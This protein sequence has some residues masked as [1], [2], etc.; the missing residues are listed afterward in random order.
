MKSSPLLL[1]GLSLV[2]L[3]MALGVAVMSVD[4][5]A[6]WMKVAVVSP[7][8]PMEIALNPE[9]KRKT[10]VA[11]SIKDGE[12]KFGSDAMGVCVKSP[13]NCYVYMFDL[14]GKKVDH[15]MVKAYQARF[16]QYKIEADP[17]RGTVVFRHD[18]DTTYSVEELLGMMFAH[19]KTQ[20][21]SFTEQAVKDAVI[22]TPVYF[23]QAER[24]ALVA[25]AQLGGLNVLQLMNVPMAV[26]L[27]YGMFRRKEINGTV[28]HLMLYDMGAQ[29]TTATIVGFQVVK[30]KEK[31]FSE[32]HPQAQILGV[33]YD[34][35]LGGAEIRFRVRDYL[36]DQFNALGKTKTDVKS[37][38]RAMG[39]LLKEAERVKLILSANADC[40]AQIEN[41]MED[42]DFKV[43]MSRDK[44]M[45]LST[46]LMDRVTGPVERALSTA[47]MSIENIDQVI[48]VG[49]GTRV[50]RV[51][52]LLSEYVGQELGKSLNTDESAAMGAV[53][54]SADIS[55]GFK[56]KKFLMKDAVLLPIDVDFSREIEA[57]E[58]AG[59][60][61]V[62]R[63][64]RTLFSRM[65]PY[66]Q[67]K[68][69][70]FNKHV[71]DFTFNV[72]YADLDYLGETEVAHIGSHNLTSVLVKGVKG[73]LDGNVE[74]NI[75]TKGVKAHFQ[76]DDSGILTCTHVES[77]F[78]KTISPE[79]QEKKEKDWKEATESIDWSK[80][81]DNIKNFFGTD[82]KKEEGTEGDEEKEEK[83]EDKDDVKKEKDSKDTKKEEKKDKKDEKS[84]EPKKPK[85]ESVKVELE[86]D[87]TRNDLELLD[88]ESFNSSKAKLDE[89]NQ[90]D[91][92]RLAIETALNELQSFSFD[93][94][95]KMEDDEFQSASSAEERESVV[96]ECGKVSEWLDD[97]AGMFTPVEEFTTKLK[98][99]KDLS[100]PIMARVREHK[101]RPEALEQLRQTINSSNVFL[102]KSKEYLIKPKPKE[103]KVEKVIEPVVETAGEEKEGANEKAKETAE[104]KPKVTK[105][106][107]VDEEGLFKE[108]ELDSLKKKIT[109]VEKWRD[110]KL[111]EQEKTPLAE[112]PK[113]TVSM[114]KSKIQDLDSEV[115]FLIQKARM[116]KAE[117]EREKRKLEAEEKK[118]EEE[119]LKKEKKAKKKK[120]K[121]ANATDTDEKVSEEVPPT[122]STGEGDT[123]TTEKKPEPEIVEEVNEEGNIKDN[124]E[125]PSEVP[126]EKTE[127]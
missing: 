80:L 43:P 105:A 98:V 100:A 64:R 27:N 90:A 12:R 4:I 39:K 16:P 29:A 73:A 97:E 93:L 50:P 108:K 88:G 126:E 113:L 71:K 13:K 55:T 28:K 72:N 118:A 123:D 75:E 17:E 82:E 67:K 57:E 5:G 95:D 122:E 124:A 121:E 120:A 1:L 109:E 65:N 44:L 24:L 19:A 68:I 59:E 94:G 74:D 84:K 69:M 11:V 110:D 107:I 15:P 48:L 46:D 62:K 33:G 32:T 77:V 104:E 99:L 76:L 36:A 23:N 37:V 86:I 41:V 58:E 115:Q 51:Q 49:G 119:R 3:D 45:E 81:G 54:R 9:S 18:S 34:R 116:L 106:K 7:G 103:S 61:G 63:V 125:E 89:L 56:V 20:A 70:T 22:T 111:V 10:S 53:Y 35:T 117:K 112:M 8:V 96:A 40:Y 42:I 30:T 66:P 102:E 101:E 6:E 26:A 25:A 21:E 78:E 38:P 92:D 114:I 91:L 52:D 14:L 79:E 60:P 85:I 127:L 31:G 83:K 2:G 87:G 47:S